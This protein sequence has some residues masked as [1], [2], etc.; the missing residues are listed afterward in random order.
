M[1]NKKK[2]TDTQ[3]RG[4][5]TEKKE[6]GSKKQKGTLFFFRFPTGICINDLKPIIACLRL[7]REALFIAPYHLFIPPAFIEL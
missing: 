7:M 2:D 3:K 6:D 1:T 5:M 4:S